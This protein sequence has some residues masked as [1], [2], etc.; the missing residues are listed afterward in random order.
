MNPQAMVA[1]VKSELA[2]VPQGEAGSPQSLYR[3]AYWMARMN[4]LGSRAQVPPTA[5]A[6]HELAFRCVRTSDPKLA[7]FTPRFS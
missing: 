3:A 7:E 1:T 5:E 2:H 4:S 6:A